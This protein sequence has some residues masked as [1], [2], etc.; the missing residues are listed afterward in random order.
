MSSRNSR[1]SQH[2]LSVNCSRKRSKCTKVAA[3]RG[4]A[5]AMPSHLRTSSKYLLV[6]V[7]TGGRI[8]TGFTFLHSIL[9]SVRGR[10]NLQFHTM[11][12][13]M[14]QITPCATD[15]QSPFMY[16][17][18]LI[19]EECSWG[20]GKKKS[21]KDSAPNGWRQNVFAYQGNQYLCD[22]DDAILYSYHSSSTPL[23]AITNKSR[24][25]SWIG[26]GLNIVGIVFSLNS[27]LMNK[28]HGSPPAEYNL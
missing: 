22:D 8:L 1:R 28:F 14:K 5:P 4:G 16:I 3:I 11:Q 20:C 9:L 25:Y 24:Q 27:S 2:V 7:T 23:L 12:K 18:Y 13:K 26:I 19:E 17:N 15:R 6:I 21:T 10:E